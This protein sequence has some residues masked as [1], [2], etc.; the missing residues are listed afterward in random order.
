[1]KEFVQG[2]CA[3]TLTGSFK[4]QT[5]HIHV[6]QP[7][8]P[9][10]IKNTGNLIGGGAL[11]PIQSLTMSSMD[12]DMPLEDVI[13][14]DRAQKKGGKNKMPNKSG[15]KKQQQERRPAP[16]QSAQRGGKIG[17]GYTSRPGNGPAAAKRSTIFNGNNTKS[18]AVFPASKRGGI[19]TVS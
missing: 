5:P 19:T 7:N 14:K 1:V 10:I 18:R 4:F 8:Q 9:Q 11:Q 16:V 3:L 15:G 2:S 6:T 13:K 12:I 17:K